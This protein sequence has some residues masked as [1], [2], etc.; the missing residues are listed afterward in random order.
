MRQVPSKWKGGQR[1][2]VVPMYMISRGGEGQKQV[3]FL[4]K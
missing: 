2:V 1:P 3:E 4:C